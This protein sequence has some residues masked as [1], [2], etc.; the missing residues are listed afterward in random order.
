MESQ[1]SHEIPD[2]NVSNSEHA[3]TYNTKFQKTIDQLIK[4]IELRREWIGVKWV[5]EDE[6][7]REVRLLDYACGTGLVTRVCYYHYIPCPLLPDTIVRDM[8]IA[9]PRLCFPTSPPA[10]E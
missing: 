8:L 6:Q 7:G 1:P 5:E 10:Q 9:L 3:K 2:T 4:Q